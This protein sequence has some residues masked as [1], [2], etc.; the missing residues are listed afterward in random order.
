MIW[1]KLTVLTRTGLTM[2]VDRPFTHYD[3]FESGTIRL[4][5]VRMGLQE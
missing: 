2:N 3:R 1:R 5:V 4:R